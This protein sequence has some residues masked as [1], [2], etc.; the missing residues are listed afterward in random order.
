MAV[1]K[2]TTHASVKLA[3]PVCFVKMVGTHVASQLGSK[4]PGTKLIIRACYQ[5]IKLLLLYVNFKAEV[6]FKLS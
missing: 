6:L 1:F 4:V 2:K 5:N 3:T